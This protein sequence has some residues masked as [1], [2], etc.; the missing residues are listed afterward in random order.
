LIFTLQ[1]ISEANLKHERQTNNKL[2]AQR[3]LE[4][5]ERRVLNQLKRPEQRIVDAG[6]MHDDLKIPAK[7]SKGW[8]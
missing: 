5:A 3:H 2:A 1:R 7:K 6:L 8:F 4:K